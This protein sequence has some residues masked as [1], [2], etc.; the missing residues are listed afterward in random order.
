MATDWWNPERYRSGDKGNYTR[1]DRDVSK[2]FVDAD[3]DSDGIISRNEYKK[4][5]SQLFDIEGD[6]HAPF[7]GDKWDSGAAR[8]RALLSGLTRNNH[9]RLLFERYAN[10]Q[11]RRTILNRGA[12]IH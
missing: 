1:Y 12:L 10:S 3:A 4:W 8:Q 7:R 2:A 9:P 6:N 11:P 5:N